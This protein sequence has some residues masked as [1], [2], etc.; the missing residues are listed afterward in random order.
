MNEAQYQLLAEN[1][2]ECHWLDKDDFVVDEIKV[3][4]EQ[5]I[6]Y[7]QY[8]MGKFFENMR[9]DKDNKVALAWYTKAGENGHTLAQF[10]LGYFLEKGKGVHHLFDTNENERTS[11]VA[12]WYTEAAKSGHAEAQYRL[13]GDGSGFCPG[14]CSSDAQS[15]FWL[16]LSAY[17]DHAEAILALAIRYRDGDKIQ[18]SS[19]DALYW[20]GRHS[21]DQAKKYIAEMY[22]HGIGI[23]KDLLQ[24]IIYYDCVRG[25][26]KSECLYVISIIYKELKDN[27]KAHN[28]LKIASDS[29]SYKAQKVFRGYDDELLILL[30]QS[31]RKHG[32]AQYRLGKLYELGCA[33]QSIEQDQL[34]AVYWYKQSLKNGFSQGRYEMGLRY[35]FGS[36]GVKQ[37]PLLAIELFEECIRRKKKYGYEGLA[38][39]YKHGLGVE[40]DLNKAQELREKAKPENNSK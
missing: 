12:H 40:L 22:H 16:K 31:E 37:T 39:A 17:Q 23:K 1:L 13:A 36:D 7:A 9:S 2:Q 29:G 33:E 5:N 11:F 21:S 28:Y 14:Y 18:Q 30:A 34:K 27:V 25:G 38:L 4:A 24:A 6:P 32:N 15:T 26:M 10:K 19:S 3:L 35:L 20:F 8:L